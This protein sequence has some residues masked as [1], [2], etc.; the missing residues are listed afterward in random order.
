MRELAYPEYS[1]VP[2]NDG[3][4]RLTFNVPGS[5]FGPVAIVLDPVTAATL[6]RAI[7]LNNA[8]AA[9]RAGEPG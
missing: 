5:K 4:V 2:R 9:S 1:I 7:D 3:G 6:A 8:P